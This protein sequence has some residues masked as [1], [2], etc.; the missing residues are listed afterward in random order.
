MSCCLNCGEIVN[1]LIVDDSKHP[2][3]KPYGTVYDSPLPFRCRV[4]G[5][6][7]GFEWRHVFVPP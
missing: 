3:S 1:P 2:P 5:R 4:E 7:A 6:P